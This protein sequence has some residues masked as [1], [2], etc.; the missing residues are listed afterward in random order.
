MNQKA[1]VTFIFFSFWPIPTYDLAAARQVKSWSADSYD[2]LLK[3][4][5]LAMNDYFGEGWRFTTHQIQSMMNTQWV[6]PIWYYPFT[7]VWKLQSSGICYAKSYLPPLLGGFWPSLVTWR[8]VWSSW[9]TYGRFS[10]KAVRVW[11]RTTSS[12]SAPWTQSWSL[13]SATGSRQD[14]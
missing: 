8:V 4:T 6:F 12:V 13:S 10:T 9:S 3:G 7:I 2:F 1:K 11:T 14:S 5:L